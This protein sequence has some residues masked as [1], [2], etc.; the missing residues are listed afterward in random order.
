M[1]DG[2][3]RAIGIGERR[4]TWA[5][6]NKKFQLIGRE[7]HIDMGVFKRKDVIERRGNWWGESYR[8]IIIMREK[9]R[10]RNT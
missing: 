3:V 8:L 10:E 1:K 7:K 9:E 2:E 5:K 6:Q 4:N